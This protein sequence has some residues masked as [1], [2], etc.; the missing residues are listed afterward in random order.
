VSGQK[1]IRSAQ[2]RRS[3][4]AR[5]FARMERHELS[6]ADV[7]NDVPA[8]LKRVRVFD[9]VR[10]FPHM[11]DDG[12]DNV[13]RRAKVWPVTRMGKLA[14][15]ERERILDSLPPRARV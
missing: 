12:A 9:V 1:Q 14:E 6:P 15:E 2:K 7:L 4:I 8:C 5:L 11:G 13:L 10:R 3:Q